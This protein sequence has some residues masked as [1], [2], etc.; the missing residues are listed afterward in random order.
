M[1]TLRRNSIVALAAP[2]QTP[3][4]LGQGTKNNLAED[5][6]LRYRH[7]RV[8]A[9]R[10]LEAHTHNLGGPRADRCL[11]NATLLSRITKRAREGVGRHKK[12]LSP[13]RTLSST[14]TPQWQ[15]V[16]T[17]TPGP[18]QRKNKK[19]GKLAPPT[20]NLDGRN[21]GVESKPP[22]VSERCASKAP[23]RKM[24]YSE[25]AELDRSRVHAADEGCTYRPTRSEAAR[26]K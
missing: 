21:D 9:K 3:I 16:G 11:C 6:K 4:I 13:T 2:P 26:L 15:R 25:G 24:N 8:W 14:S 22:L 1:P 12:S 18:T 5:H 7:E 20:F 10:T 17:K 19:R 23:L